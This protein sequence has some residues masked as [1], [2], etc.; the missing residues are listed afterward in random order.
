MTTLAF[1]TTLCGTCAKSLAAEI[2]RED[3]RAVMVKR[4]SEHGEQRVTIAADADWYVATMAERPELETPPDATKPIA[5]GCP[6]DCGTCTAHEQ[7]IHL[8]VVPV[9]SACNLECPICYTHNKSE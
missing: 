4:C 8:P 3:G 6:F 5:Q 9:T 1:T 7:R 2:V